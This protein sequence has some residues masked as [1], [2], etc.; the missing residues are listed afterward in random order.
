MFEAR[1]CR[2]L[3][4]TMSEA[5]ETQSARISTLECALEIQYY[6]E[7]SSYGIDIYRRNIDGKR[8]SVCGAE[9]VDRNDLVLYPICTQMQFVKH[10]L[11]SSLTKNMNIPNHAY[12]LA[13]QDR[14]GDSII[15]FRYDDECFASFDRQESEVSGVDITLNSAIAFQALKTMHETH[16]FIITPKKTYDDV[17]D[18]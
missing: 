10:K 12:C 8:R 13:L 6:D 14:N 5:L 17:F 15:Y 4:L 16:P 7:L 1:K 11:F 18:Y 3:V 2:A 9:F